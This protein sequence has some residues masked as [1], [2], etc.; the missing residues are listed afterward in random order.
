MKT[1]ERIHVLMTEPDVNG[2]QTARG[3]M[4]V[5]LQGNPFDLT[6]EEFDVFLPELVL[7]SEIDAMKTTL[8]SVEMQAAEKEAA[9]KLSI[10]K[11][12]KERDAAL[13]Q[14][15]T[16]MSEIEALKTPTKVLK[17]TKAQARIALLEAGLLDQIEAGIQAME[18][19]ARTTTLIF[20]NDSPYYSR[21]GQLITTLAASFGLTEQMLDALFDAASKKEG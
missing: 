13:S 19:P 6:K 8:A 15:S 11:L 17:V 7:V 1:L 12:E 10:E 9:S 2:S 14:I 18:E 3:Y 20:W 5:D 16:L 4:A 21:D